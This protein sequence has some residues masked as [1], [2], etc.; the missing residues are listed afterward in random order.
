[1]GGMPIAKPQFIMRQHGA[2]QESCDAELIILQSEEEKVGNFQVLE[3]KLQTESRTCL[4][5]GAR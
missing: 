5:C 1:M 2:R 3:R 4:F